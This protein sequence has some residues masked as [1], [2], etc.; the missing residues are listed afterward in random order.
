MR[1][2]VRVVLAIALLMLGAVVLWSMMSMPGEVVGVGS[3][4]HDR[5]DVAG[6]DNPVT[7]VLLN[8]RAYDT[9]LEM[10]VL[11]LALMAVW[12]LQKAPAKHLAESA[13]PVLSTVV[14]LLVPLMV[15]VGGYLLWAGG[16][17]PG[18]AFQGGAVLAAA[19]ILLLLADI[20]AV[21]LRAAVLRAGIAL[22][23]VVFVAAGLVCLAAGGDFLEYPEGWAGT[24]IVLIE[25]AST[26][27][28]WL[29]LAG[30]FA[31]RPRPLTAA[32]HSEEGP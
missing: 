20:P 25:A 11:A 30:I 5:L 12:S 10:V 29:I 18:G 17:E 6:V 27:S 19:G 15:L 22:G 8:F 3:T 21:R 7:A 24:T 2:A 1:P 28:T 32:D 31:G 14:S 13:G 23:L 16:S 4:I 9:L 26:I